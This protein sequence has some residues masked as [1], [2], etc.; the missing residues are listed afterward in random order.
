MNQYLQLKTFWIVLEK[1][2]VF[3]VLNNQQDGII[4]TV[5]AYLMIPK[6]MKINGIKERIGETDTMTTR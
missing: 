1:Y 6:L 5:A 4:A 3:Q 2:H